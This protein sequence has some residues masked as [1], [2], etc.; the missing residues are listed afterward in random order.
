MTQSTQTIQIVS[1]PV[2]GMTCV[3]CVNR[4][5]RYRRKV[6]GVEG[7]ARRAPS[8]PRRSNWRPSDHER[9]G[10]QPPSQRH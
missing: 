9:T 3:S 4:I 1:F 7:A 8:P 2:E 6:D 10:S 5:T